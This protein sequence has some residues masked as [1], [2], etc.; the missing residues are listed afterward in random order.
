MWLWIKGYVRD[1]WV[2]NRSQ[3]LIHLHGLYNAKNESLA[4]ETVCPRE[5]EKAKIGRV[6]KCSHGNWASRRQ[7]PKLEAQRRAQSDF[8]SMQ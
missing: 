2:F 7:D 3:E 5:S 1:A 6:P 4:H 8:G